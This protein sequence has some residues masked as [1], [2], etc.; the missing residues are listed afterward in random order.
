MQRLLSDRSFRAHTHTMP[1]VKAVRVHANCPVLG[2]RPGRRPP[3]SSA[4]SSGFSARVH[5]RQAAQV[6]AR[7]PSVLAFACQSSAQRAPDLEQPQERSGAGVLSARSR[8]RRRAATADFDTLNPWRC[9]GAALPAS[10]PRAP[11]YRSTLPAPQMDGGHQ[12]ATQPA[13]SHGQRCRQL[14]RWRA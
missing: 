8:R 9:A 2:G 1:V 11:Q 3:A 12:P 6:G 14:H 7:G 5:E 10:A 13:H 4:S